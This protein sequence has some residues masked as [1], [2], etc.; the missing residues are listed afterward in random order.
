MDED[1]LLNVEFAYTPWRGSCRDIY[2]MQVTAG[3]VRDICCR[4]P[5]GHEGQCGSGWGDGRVRWTKDAE[6]TLRAAA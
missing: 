6:C 4:R 3:G 2:G 5:L 1:E